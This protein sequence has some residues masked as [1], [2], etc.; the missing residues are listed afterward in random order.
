MTFKELIDGIESGFYQIRI[1]T[2]VSIEHYIFQFIPDSP[3]IKTNE[4]ITERGRDMVQNYENITPKD[5]YAQF[6]DIRFTSEVD[7]NYELAD[8][9]DLK[10]LREEVG[11]D[12][13]DDKS[14]PIYSSWKN[15]EWTGTGVLNKESAK[16]IIKYFLEDW[17]DPFGLEEISSLDSEIPRA[18]YEDW[19]YNF[20][21]GNHYGS[22]PSEFFRKDKYGIGDAIDEILELWERL[23]D[24]KPTE[25]IDLCCTSSFYFNIYKLKD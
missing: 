3:E 15:T 12:F 1:R 10:V 14:L 19:A 6:C 8:N 24:N 25:G 18:F 13:F 5:V 4:V 9:H 17:E 2:T 22:L 20:F 7:N 11:D 23:K 16:D 21:E